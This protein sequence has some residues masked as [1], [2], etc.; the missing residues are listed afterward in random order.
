MLTVYEGAA[1]FVEDALPLF[2]ADV[3]LSD[4]FVSCVL[5]GDVCIAFEAIDWIDMILP[6]SYA[7][8]AP[9]LT[10]INHVPLALYFF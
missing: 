4:A 3:L 1:V 5:E 9:S 2:A 10:A 6:K 7:V 8:L